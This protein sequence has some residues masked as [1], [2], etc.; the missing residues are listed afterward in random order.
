MPLT[1]AT[2]NNSILEGLACGTP[3]VATDLDGVRDYCT[4]ACGGL[5]PQGDAAAHAEA[6][7]ALLTD[8]ELRHAAGIAARAAAE[9]VSWPVVRKAV[10]GVL[11]S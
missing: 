8:P 4:A 5:S 1:D 11:A 6:T 7:I 9:R 2:A 3:V 10:Q